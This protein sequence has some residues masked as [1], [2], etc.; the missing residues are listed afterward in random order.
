MAFSGLAGQVILTGLKTDIL[1]PWLLD[2]CV[3]KERDCQPSWAGRR[4][5]ASPREPGSERDS[6]IHGCVPVP[7]TGR[8]GEAWAEHPA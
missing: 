3:Q 1:G 7:A 5:A 4:V 8:S 2:A 6:G